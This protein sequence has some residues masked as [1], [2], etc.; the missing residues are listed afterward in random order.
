MLIVVGLIVGLVNHSI[1]AQSEYAT[2]KRVIDGDTI[3]LGTGETVRYI[4]IDAPE[5]VHP[6]KPVE[7]YGKEASE[8]NRKLVEGEKVKLEFDVERKDR[9]G[10]TLAY[11]YLSNGLFVNAKMVGSGYARV[12][13]YAPNVKY[14]NNFL[15]MERV[16]RTNRLG[17]WAKPAEPPSLEEQVKKLSEAVE[18]LSSQVEHLQEL[19]N[20]IMKRLDK[21]EKISTTERQTTAST[22]IK[23]EKTPEKTAT[24]TPSMDDVTVYITRT[25]KKYHSAGC[26]YLRKS[27]IQKKKTEAVRG[28]YTPCSRCLP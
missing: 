11:V 5:T 26:S 12:S 1:P 20:S 6:N 4:G 27:K 10:R 15:N 19:A 24:K 21:L 13:T 2:V 14:A 22:S 23:V 17:L 25:G 9:Y 28:G 18:K 8:F 3:E 16:A 7:Y